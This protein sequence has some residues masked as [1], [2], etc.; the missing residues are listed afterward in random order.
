MKCLLSKFGIFPFICFT[1]LAISGNPVFVESANSPQTK[2]YSG[3]IVSV[4]Q[5]LDENTDTIVDSAIGPLATPD[6]WIYTTLATGFT[7][8][9][10]NQEPFLFNN[11]KTGDAVALWQ[12]ADNEN[13]IWIGAAT[14]PSGATGWSIT[15]FSS[16]NNIGTFNDQVAA[17]DEN[18]N[19]TVTWTAYNSDF[20]T[21]IIGVT[22][23]TSPT[24]S[25]GTPF[26]LAE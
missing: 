12:Y 21:C 1:L 13:N 2:I 8:G 5:D 10:F 18:G 16:N 7:G 4:W 14:L 24:V 23:T 11:G 3:N 15:S 9:G 19:V 25:W 6:A 17:I 20:S 22:G 26:T